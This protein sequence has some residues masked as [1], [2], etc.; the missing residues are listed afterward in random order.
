MKWLA[1]MLGVALLLLQYR[2]WLSD[3]GVYQVV[4]A[5]PQSQT[6]GLE[7]AKAPA[8]PIRTAAR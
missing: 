1:G 5:Q 8:I 7:T 2:L 4:P 6:Q 3:S